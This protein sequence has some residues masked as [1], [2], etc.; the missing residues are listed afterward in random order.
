M[1]RIV[2][3]D[4]EPNVL[5][6]LRRMLRSWR[7]EWDLVFCETGE[8][9]LSALAAAP[10][11]VLVTD[12]MMPQMDGAELV[13]LASEQHPE[14]V[15]MVLTGHADPRR[16][17][18]VSGR[19]HQI[20]AK[21]CDPDVL[22]SVIQRTVALQELYASPRLSALVGGAQAVPAMPRLYMEL[23][24]VLRQ[25]NSDAAD[26]AGVIEQDPGMTA[27]ILQW[28]N[29][30][31]FGLRHRVMAAEQAVALL[32]LETI[33][34]LVLS[35]QVFT[36]FRVGDVPGFDAEFVAQHSLAVAL[37]ARAVAQA[38]KSKLQTCED[39]FLAGLLHDVGKLYLAANAP[40]AYGEVLDLMQRRPT[41]VITAEREVL[42]A[43]HAEAG[44]YLL[45]LWG[46][47]SP[48]VEA[49]AFHHTPRDSVMPGFEPLVA[50]HVANVIDNDRRALPVPRHTRRVDDAWLAQLGLDNDLPQWQAAAEQRVGGA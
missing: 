12:M 41:D 43:T 19:V 5:H 30:P 10:T 31:F 49:V 45:G 38:A 2:F 16:L 20:L 25:E 11:Q 7:D 27:K 42:G 36:Q 48:V 13:R 46:L 15:R 39:A 32:G 14:T 33:R 6:G 40:E 4:D 37:Q 18:A 1:K 50:V 44:A 9:A 22:R 29:S 24:D 8:D 26:V 23:M 47:S 17:F 21:P 3:V 28:V 35:A 34:Q